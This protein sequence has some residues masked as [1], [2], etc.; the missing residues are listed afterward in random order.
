[1]KRQFE[2]VVKTVEYDGKR[3]RVYGYD[4]TATA[5]G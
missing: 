3:M 1:M 4:E 2:L 5:I